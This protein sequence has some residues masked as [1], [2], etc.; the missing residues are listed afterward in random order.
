MTRKAGRG[1]DYYC[2]EAVHSLIEYE[3]A[4]TIR[5]L[6]THEYRVKFRIRQEGRLSC[7]CVCLVGADG[8]FCKHCLAEGLPAFE[9][10]RY[11]GG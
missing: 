5:V 10:K 2:R 7:S 9:I 8:L 11:M 6:G 4:P 3:G 1:E